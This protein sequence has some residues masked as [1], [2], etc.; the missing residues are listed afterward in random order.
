MNKMVCNLKL[1][2]FFMCAILLNVYLGDALI[3][4]INIYMRSDI[5]DLVF[6]KVVRGH[7]KYI[8]CVL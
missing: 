4:K 1:I 8:E 5:C 7:F 2:F 6:N 3:K